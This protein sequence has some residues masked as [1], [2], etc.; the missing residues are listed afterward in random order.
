MELRHLRY[1]LAVAD[2]LNFSRAAER[3]RV[4]QPALSR[5]IHDL[6][7]HLGFKLFERS[8]TKVHL[9]EAGR[10]FRQQVEKLLMQL[11]I[12]VTGAQRIANGT[13][14]D[15][16]IGTGWISSG[17]FVTD[18]ARELRQRSPE[19]SIDFVE[20]PDHEHI[21]AIRDQKIDVGFV[22][23][24]NL[25]P[26][27]DIDYCSLR[28]CELKAILP[29]EHPLANEAEIR[30]R[31][32]KEERWITIEEEEIPGFK[33]LIT[34]ILRPAQFTPKFGRSARSFKSMLDFIGTGQGI[35]LLPQ[36]LLPTTPVGIRCVD[37]DCAPIELCAVWSKDRANA[38]VS[39]YLEIVRRKIEE[40]R[41]PAATLKRLP[42]RIVPSTQPVRAKQ[43]LAGC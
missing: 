43:A 17:L 38:H 33:V 36:F 15:F 18:A 24:N 4:A 3:L 6:E 2:A 41:M 32:L 19:I 11:D 26:R 28:T 10:F 39:A 40:S 12:A 14:S 27:K 23:R 35:A 1:F 25:T 5:Q 31:D 13:T 20:L 21:Q 29:I 9:T 7:E 30:L 34:Q 42:G 16:T 22:S 8:T 37:T